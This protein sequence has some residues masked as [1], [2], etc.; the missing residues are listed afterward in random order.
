MPSKPSAKTKTKTKAAKA[1][2]RPSHPPKPRVHVM[3]TGGTISMKID[4]ATHAAVP[5]FS[6]KDI[7]AHVPGLRQ[8]ARLTIE[9]YARLPGPHVGPRWM[10][11]LKKRIEAHLAD[12]SIDG[13]VVA[14]G[15]DT[16]EETSFLVDLTTDSE[17]PVVFCGAM[18]T[19]G[20]AGSDAPS[21]LMIAV[22]TAA[23]PHARGHGVLIAVGEEILAAS[24]AVKTHTQSL[25]AFKSEIGPVAILDRSG[26]RFV[27]GAVRRRF[28]QTGSIDPRVD[29]HVMATGSD[30]RL[31]RASLS[32]GARGLVIEGTGAGNV[33]PL[34]ITAIK[35]AI[36][37]QVPVVITSRCGAGSVAPLYGY[38]GGGAHL[39]ELGCVMG[40]NLVGH[41]ARI[42]LMVA[43]AAN[44]SDLALTALFESA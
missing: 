26:V 33:P 7:V 30:D 9:D 41:K 15:T 36:A 5:M 8:V 6:G 22:N 12:P 21:N 34:A 32:S 35:E 40:G 2:P 37:S 27:R 19:L 38:E 28:I 18:R 17:K 1:A 25:G 16:I 43:L 3:F 14:H 13:V 23:N 44:V 20:E 39:L 31:I 24:E 10:W 42:L 11:S 29:L 4:P